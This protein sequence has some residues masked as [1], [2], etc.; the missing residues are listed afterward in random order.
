MKIRRSIWKFPYSNKNFIFLKNKI[1]VLNRNISLTSSYL[2][3][4]LKCHKGNIYGKL[5]ITKQHLNHKL[6]EFFFTKVLGDRIAYR[7]RQKLLLKR[8]RNKVKLLKK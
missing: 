4:N 6:G 5:L 8:Q 3:Q 1:K 7:K 2:N